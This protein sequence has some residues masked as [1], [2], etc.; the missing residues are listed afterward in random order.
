M[1]LLDDKNTTTFTTNY[2][3]TSG[4]NGTA[5]SVSDTTINPIKRS[6]NISDV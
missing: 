3:S 5:L 4:I 2:I 1:E 6:L